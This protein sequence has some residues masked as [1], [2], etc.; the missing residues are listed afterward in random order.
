M[1]HGIAS[2]ALTDSTVETPKLTAGD[3]TDGLKLSTTPTLPF[4]GPPAA[5]ASILAGLPSVTN[6]G[7]STAVI[8]V[9]LE[10]F[11]GPGGAG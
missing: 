8:T 5:S 7:A 3:T 6:N 4:V 2:F 9:T 1:L 10:R 11:D